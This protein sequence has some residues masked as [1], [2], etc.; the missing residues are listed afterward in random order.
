MIS[1]PFED[2]LYQV[3]IHDCPSRSNDLDR[4]RN[5]LTRGFLQQIPLRTGENGSPEKAPVVVDREE[6]NRDLRVGLAN[7]PTDINAARISYLSIHDHDIDL[8]RFQ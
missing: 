1:H 6:K 4:F 8:T 7:S 2:V 5:G 3:L